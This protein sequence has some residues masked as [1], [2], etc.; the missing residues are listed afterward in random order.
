M[1]KLNSENLTEKSFWVISSSWSSLRIIWRGFAAKIGAR[2][3]CCVLVDMETRLLSS[4]APS[5]SLFLLFVLKIQVHLSH[6]P[7]VTEGNFPRGALHSTDEWW[8]SWDVGFFGLRKE[9]PE[10]KLLICIALVRPWKFYG[11]YSD[12]P[13]KCSLVNEKSQTGSWVLKR[14]FHTC[15]KGTWNHKSHKKTMG[16]QPMRSS[17]TA[18][19]RVW[20][21]FS[22]HCP[23]LDFFLVL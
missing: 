14:I 6:R 16:I 9:F 13:T 17:E 20:K 22:S 5:Q 2:C 10:V 12:R 19:L 1:P 21:I 3:Y 23:G 8:T 18:F 11:G 7:E 15:T 4:P